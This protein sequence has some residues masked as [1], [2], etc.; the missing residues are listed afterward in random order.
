MTLLRDE[1]TNEQLTQARFIKKSD[2]LVLMAKDIGKLALAGIAGLGIAVTA[3]YFDN[4]EPSEPIAQVG[5]SCNTTKKYSGRSLKG[6][7]CT[8]IE[9]SDRTVQSVG[10][11]V[12]SIFR[13]KYSTLQD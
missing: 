3:M 1:T 9:A 7:Y 13:I 2:F 4:P 12:D 6:N 5:D 11:L 10:N 8:E